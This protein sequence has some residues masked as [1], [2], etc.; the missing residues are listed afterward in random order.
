M[1]CF[2]VVTEKDE[3][4]EQVVDVR[5]VHR[6]E[7]HRSIVLKTTHTNKNTVYNVPPD[8]TKTLNRSLEVFFTM[9][10]HSKY[11]RGSFLYH[12]QLS[13]VNLNAPEE[14]IKQLQQCPSG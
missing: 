2:D 11:L 6:Q 1:R 8:T 3:G 12:L 9:L 10:C 5:L 7:D 4:D 13:F 14:A